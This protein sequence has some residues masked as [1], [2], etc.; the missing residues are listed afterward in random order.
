MSVLPV[1]CFQA[2]LTGGHLEVLRWVREH[3]S[4]NYL[5]EKHQVSFALD[6]RAADRRCS[7]EIKHNSSAHYI[8]GYDTLGYTNALGN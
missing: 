4:C 7:C 3:E 6:M 1:D 8:Y 5:H 2:L